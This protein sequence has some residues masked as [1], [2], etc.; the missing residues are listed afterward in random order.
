MQTK[1]GLT[2]EQ[3]KKVIQ[4]SK[5]DKNNK[6][7]DST[8][9]DLEDELELTLTQKLNLVI[10]GSFFIG[11]IYVLNKDYDSLVTVWFVRMFPREASIFGLSSIVDRI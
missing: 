11:L 1:F 8:F 10:Y 6:N 5:S 2:E 7:N 4:S 9:Q 3:V